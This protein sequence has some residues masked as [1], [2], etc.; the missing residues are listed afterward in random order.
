[1][2]PSLSLGW[3]ISEERFWDR[4]RWMVNSFKLRLSYGTTGNQN[5]ADYSYAPAIYKNY[6]YAFGT[7]AKS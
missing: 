4:L 6:D 2:F 5:F 1:M 7:G 3:N